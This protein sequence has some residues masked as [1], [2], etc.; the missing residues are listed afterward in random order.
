MIRCIAVYP[1]DNPASKTMQWEQYIKQAKANGFQEVFSSIHLPEFT[2]EKQINSLLVLSELVHRYKMDLCVDIGG[3]YIAEILKNKEL[4]QTIRKCRIDTVRLDYGYHHDQIALLYKKLKLKGFV[5]N[6]SIYSAEEAEQ[7]IQFLQSISSDLS[8]KGCHNF[9][10]M[11]ETG[12]DA[13]FAKEQDKV[14]KRYN[15]PVFYC[16]PSMTNPR[17]PML[18]GLPTIE[19]HRYAGIESIMLDLIHSYDC[20]AIMLADEFCDESEL[21]K[22]NRILEKKPIPIHVLFYK[23]SS[24]EKE[25]VLKSHVFRYDSN[26]SILRSQTSREMACFAKQIIPCSCTKRHA[27]DIVILNR[28]AKRYSGEMQVAECE[29]PRSTMMNVIGKIDPQSMELLSYYRFGYTYE[30]L[31]KA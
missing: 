13:E 21:I 18:A 25:I 6:A 29:L 3:S 17:A 23:V 31:E 4:L 16:I 27:R 15:L 10:P 19:K 11:P 8:I 9:Y 26:S 20:D 28:N 24:E 22:I 2:L 1:A 7:E 30:F 5:L 14:F 12:L